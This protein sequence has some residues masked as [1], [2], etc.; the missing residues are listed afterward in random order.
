MNPE[1]HDCVNL[2]VMK[3][4]RLCSGRKV[5]KYTSVFVGIGVSNAIFNGGMVLAQAVI[6]S[7][8]NPKLFF[9]F[10]PKNH[11]TYENQ[12]HPIVIF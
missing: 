5:A 6:V 2:S 8:S 4:G 1:S 12:Y 3:S 7:T 11:C 9:A 10:I